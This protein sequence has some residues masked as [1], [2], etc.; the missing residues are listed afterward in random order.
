[1]KVLVIGKGGREHALV[2]AVSRSARV[3]KIY[4]APGNPGMKDL[5]ECVDISDSDVNGLVAFAKEK[6]IDLTIVGPESSLSLGV[7]DAFQKEGLKIFGP[8]K[9]AAQVE[10]SKDF[11]KAIMAKYGIPTAAYQTFDNKEDA[12]HYV[13]SEGAPIVIKEDGLK[14]GKGVT[15]AYTLK[16]A[17]D[18]LDIAFDIPGNKVVIEECLVGFEFSLICFVCDDIVLPMQVAQDHKCAF[19]GD[20]GPNTGGMGVYS[21]VRKITPEIIEDAMHSIM[22]PMA[23]AMVKEGHPFT[24]FLYGG[25]MLTENGIKTIEFN[26][27]FGD[28][29]A[30][31]ILPR[32][33]SDFCDVVENIMNHAKTELEWDDRVTLGVVMASDGYPAS[34]TKDAVIKGLDDV[35]SMIFHMGTAEKDGELVT[36]GGRVLIVVSQEDTLQQA[37]DKAYAD[38][39]KVQCDQLFYR[40]DIG[41]KDM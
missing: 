14:A 20:M 1:M 2:H 41:K 23:K 27:R 28:P 13:E 37:Y 8:T 16:E 24:G 6:E 10:S 5:A 15:V 32:L 33:K 30:E 26:A 21:P 40:H 3:H 29:E 19:D 38:V 9:D 18:A 4:A 12:I 39:A 34:S 25:L 7:V 17:L 11:A 35:D 36:A 22:I 31:V